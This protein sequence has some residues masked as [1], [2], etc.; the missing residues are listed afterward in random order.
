MI[1]KTFFSLICLLFEKIFMII[2]IIQ[3]Y[4]WITIQPNM[5]EQEKKLQRIYDL[6]NADLYPKFLILPYRKQRKRIYRKGAF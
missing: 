2:S 6:I 5:S 4:F 3:V 1:F